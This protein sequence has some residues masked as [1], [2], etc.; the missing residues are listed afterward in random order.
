MAVRLQHHQFAAD[1]IDASA[2]ICTEALESRLVIAALRHAIEQAPGVTEPGF[3]AEFGGICHDDQTRSELSRIIRPLRAGPPDVMAA[4]GTCRTVPAA[5]I[6]GRARPVWR[7]HSPKSRLRRANCAAPARGR[8]RHR[9]GS[10][11][12]PYSR[13]KS[14]PAP[15]PWHGRAASRRT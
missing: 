11:P 9:S 6:A 13:T 3:G 1:E 14:L 10:C 2:L 12:A 4:D 5:A 8:G 7:R 15:P